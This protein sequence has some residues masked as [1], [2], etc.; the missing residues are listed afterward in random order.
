MAPELLKVF[1]FHS[2]VS[3]A[4][5]RM[6]LLPTSRQLQR[7]TTVHAFS[8]VARIPLHVTMMRL[9]MTTTAA[10]ISAAIRSNLRMMLTA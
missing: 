5:A 10:V 2:L 6:D 1:S 7:K 4:V 9:R 8:Q 3:C